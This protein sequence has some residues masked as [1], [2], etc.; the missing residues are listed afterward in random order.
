M[1]RFGT[2][3][4]LVSA[5]ILL[6][7][8][9]T[10]PNPNQQQQPHQKFE[11]KHSFKGP[12]LAQKDGTIPFWEISGDA[13]ASAEQLRLAPSIRSKQGSAW[14]TKPMTGSDFWQV[15]ISLKVTGQGRIGADGLA[16][17]YTSAKGTQGPVFG[18]NNY[19]TG[20]GMFFDSF[21][22]D[23]QRN[24][25]YV[26][27]MVN[28]GT[29]A[30]DHNSDGSTQQLA[31]CQK[32]FRNRPYPVK[33]RVTYYQNVLTV[34]F[35][36]GMTAQERWE[37]CLRADN[38]FLPKN[39]YFGISAATGG[40]ADDHDIL[41]F[42]VSSL[43]T[44]DQVAQEHHEQK[45]VLPETE[46]KEMEQAY[47]KQMKEFEAEKEKFRKEHPEKAKKEDV[48]YGKLYEDAMERELRMIFEGQSSIHKSLQSLET[49]VKQVQS[50]Q[51]QHTSQLNGIASQQGGG[52]VPHSQ[53]AG[54]QQPAAGAGAGAMQR[55][56]VNELMQ[57]IRE[58]HASLKEM[59]TYTSD[60]HNRVINMDSRLAGQAHGGSTGQGGA[61][62][63]F[64]LVKAHLEG[65]KHD[66]EQVRI[67]QRGSP[68]GC[69]SVDNS[70]LGISLFLIVIGAQ[71]AL[72][73]MYFML[74]GS[75]EKAKFY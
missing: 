48:D 40:L 34:L 46:R 22:N 49:L 61:G 2:I 12:N 54:V 63:D 70:C 26:L 67:N 3:K 23:A 8:A 14:N 36:D 56:E 39:G 51:N 59:R 35:H 21:D 33:T 17:W 73:L 47:E 15:D 57:L 72:F 19:W 31:G 25:P 9:Q 27:A 18:A 32:D 38:V 13:I 68:A 66:V 37:L 74:K 60:V 29:K 53:P 30:Y 52:A 28:D 65:L 45:H 16:F 5:L 71:S 20:L 75:G 43:R 10:P 62:F 4:A 50:L 6:V 11:Y 42:L 44:P 1:A 7:N 24:N 69:P 58:A 55:H 41:S 64:G